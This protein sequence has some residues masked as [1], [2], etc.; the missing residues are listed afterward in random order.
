MLEFGVSAAAKNK[1]ICAFIL[2]GTYDVVEIRVRKFLF[3]NYL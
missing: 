3:H 2:R 1:E